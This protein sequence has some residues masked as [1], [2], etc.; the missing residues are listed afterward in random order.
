MRLDWRNAPAH[1]CYTQVTND[2]TKLQITQ[3]HKK[4]Q[5]EHD[6]VSVTH[7]LEHLLAE[8]TF[9]NSSPSF[10]NCLVSSSFSWTHF[11]QPLSSL[12][13]W[14]LVIGLS[15]RVLQAAQCPLHHVFCSRINPP[16]TPPTPSC[17]FLNHANRAVFN[18]LTRFYK[19]K[20]PGSNK[21]ISTFLPD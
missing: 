17:S 21:E 9:P 6:C 5:Q 3:L 14:H 15:P 4:I 18:P 11:L 13:K 19:Q 7:L 12:M 2:V 8:R 16:C 1:D 20:L 10:H